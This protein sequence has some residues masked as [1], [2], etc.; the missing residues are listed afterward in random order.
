MRRFSYWVCIAHCNVAAC[1]TLAYTALYTHS[2]S[3]V[4]NSVSNSKPTVQ[5]YWRFTLF[6]DRLPMGS[7]PSLHAFPSPP[8]CT[9]LR[10]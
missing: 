1:V 5:L 3:H 7:L 2:S 9:K 10:G 6:W 4:V 8:L